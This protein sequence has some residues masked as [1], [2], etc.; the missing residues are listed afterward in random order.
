MPTPIFPTKAEGF[1]DKETSIISAALRADA[2]SNIP[3][4][5]MY[6]AALSKDLSTI[7]KSS[8]TGKSSEYHISWLFKVLF[9]AYIPFT[10]ATARIL[11]RIYLAYTYNNLSRTPRR[12]LCGAARYY[13]IAGSQAFNTMLDVARTFYT[14]HKEI[15][16]KQDPM[17]Y[18]RAEDT[19]ARGLH[20]TVSLK[21]ASTFIRPEG[22]TLESFSRR[23]QDRVPVFKKNISGYYFPNVLG[24]KFEMYADL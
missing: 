21:C 8:G 19:L 5:F 16:S 18:S 15:I 3:F 4:E 9:V 17:D 24:S 7:S 12:Q 11:A 1:S 14:E 13:Q 22:T 2:A 10:I 23:V 6:A 20:Y